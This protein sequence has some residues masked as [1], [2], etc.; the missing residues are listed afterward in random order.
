MS[1][2]L[3]TNEYLPLVIQT[4]DLTPLAEVFPLRDFTD[5]DENAEDDA[6]AERARSIR[7][8]LLDGVEAGM[9]P[10][11]EAGWL[12]VGFECR[13]ARDDSRVGDVAARA[14]REGDEVAYP[15]KDFDANCDMEDFA[16]QVW[17]GAWDALDTDA[18]WAAAHAT[19][20]P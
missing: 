6:V 4:P 18:I 10:L 16:Q 20:T 5:L 11:V 14:R 13:W 2:T 17:A 12:A 15:S 19:V 9:R 1:A 8:A 7:L 3:E